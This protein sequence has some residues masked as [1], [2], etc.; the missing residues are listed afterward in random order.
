MGKKLFIGL[1]IVIAILAIGAYVLLAPPGVDDAL[2][3]VETGVVEVNLGSG[4]QTASDEMKIAPGA[5]VRTQEGEAMIV[6][7][8]GEVIKLE[9]NTEMTLS[10]VGNSIKLDQAKGQTWHKVTKI[11][12]VTDYSA[13][14]PNTV[15]TVRGTEFFLNDESTGVTEGNVDYQNKETGE[16]VNVPPGQKGMYPGL[17]LLGLTEE[18]IAAATS[19]RGQYIATLK[20]VRMREIRKHKTLIN[21]A[22]SKGYTEEW[23]LAELEKI[24]R[25]E[26]DLDQLE[27]KV[28]AAFKARSRRAFALTRAIRD[29]M[30]QN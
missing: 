4:W 17:E 24:D 9:P 11:S 13:S 23:M 10:E 14:T 28:P 16:S 27:A 25:G 26:T 20:K 29:A 30:S 19:F 3:Y 22:K 15:A 18:E 1:G 12:G 6:L 21:L 8:E 5:Q 2:L 7:L